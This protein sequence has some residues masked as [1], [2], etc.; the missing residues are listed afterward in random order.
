MSVT[1]PAPAAAAALPPW[2]T[3]RAFVV[4][5]RLIALVTLVVVL[6]LLSPYF[7]TWGNITNIFRQASVQF[8]MAA[9]LTLVVLAGGIDLSI[10]AVLGL[11]ACVSASLLNAGHVAAGVVAAL[12]IGLACG[13]V[14]GM[15]VTLV[16]MPAF[17]ATYG[18]LWIAQGLAV[19]FMKGD[20]IYGLPPGARVIAIGFFLGIPVPVWIGLTG[21]LL[22]HGMLHS[23]VLGR[24]IY[25]R[26][27][28]G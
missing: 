5:S 20:T 22:L 19:I 24:S 21:M 26:Y 12:A 7:L 8:L 3:D 11:A 28:S 2:L 9:G 18:M 23:T 25:A 15:L 10:G 14:N 4:V 27:L 16:R 17:M 1:A 6:S 13:F